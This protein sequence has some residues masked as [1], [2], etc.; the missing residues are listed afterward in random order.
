VN[1]RKEY[2]QREVTMSKEDKN[3]NGKRTT[4]MKLTRKKAK[5]LS[6]KRAMI[7]K[8]KKVPEGTSQMKKLKNWSFVG[9]SKQQHMALCPGKAI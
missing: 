9:I 4:E 7:E 2:Q 8:F 3:K 5:K 1:P 6:K